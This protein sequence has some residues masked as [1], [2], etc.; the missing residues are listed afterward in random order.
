MGKVIAIVIAAAFLFACDTNGCIYARDRKVYV[1]RHH[2]AK[3]SH[4]RAK[5]PP[6]RRPDR[7]KPNHNRGRRR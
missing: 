3:P 7:V 2:R 4:R 6:M 5:R 1:H